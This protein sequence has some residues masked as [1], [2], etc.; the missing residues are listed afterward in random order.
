VANAE[1]VSVL[2]LDDEQEPTAPLS[3][4][5]PPV[6]D[7]LAEVAEPPLP[8]ETGGD[9]VGDGLR[10]YLRMIRRTPLLTAVQEVALGER[11]KAGLAAAAALAA[12]PVMRTEDRRVL[13]VQAA[14][15]ERAQE[16]MVTANLRLVVSV[17]R[18]YRGLGVPLLDLVQEGNLG[19]MR[20][21]ERFD[22]DRGVKFSTYATWW[23]RQ[24]VSR[25]VADQSRLVRLP[26]H[27][28]DELVRLRRAISALSGAGHEQPSDAELGVAA[29]LATARVTQLRALPESP[30]SLDLPLGEDG[31]SS[32]GDLISDKASP[33]DETVADR[34][35]GSQLAA[36][37]CHL[38][39]RDQQLVQLRFGLLDGRARTLEQVAQ[40]LGITRERARQIE[41]RCLAIL[42]HRAVAANDNSPGA[43]VGCPGYAARCCAR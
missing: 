21:A 25:A 42:R 26:S 27:V 4:T 17:A 3:V 36:V 41:R 28:H 9:M 12:A 37:I 10:D 13:T 14:A 20:A 18:R 23:I 43:G 8:L 35:L 31:D 19:L 40:V 11:I 34:L 29:G 5:E 33:V 39:P 38:G 16:A 6:Q 30:V 15:G 7:L 2:L 24:G 32:L 1:Q 22:S